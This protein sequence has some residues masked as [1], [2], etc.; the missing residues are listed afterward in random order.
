MFLYHLLLQTRKHR[1]GDGSR[2]R[3][4]SIQIVN[5]LNSC[6]SNQERQAHEN[7]R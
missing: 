1:L 5:S 3:T 4:G 2:F 7:V 6:Y